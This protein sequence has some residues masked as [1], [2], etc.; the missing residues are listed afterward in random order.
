MAVVSARSDLRID[1]N[2][3]HLIFREWVATAAVQD[4]A[5]GG[6]VVVTI[7]MTTSATTPF[8]AD[9]LTLEIYVDAD[10][11]TQVHS[12]SLAPG[13][14]SQTV[15]LFM[16]SDTLTGSPTRCGTLRMRIHAV[17]TTG[18]P[19]GTYNV[20]TDLVN[21][22]PPSLASVATHDQGWIRST[23]TATV[24]TSNVSFGGAKPNPF[25]FPDPMFVRAVLGAI[26]Y[27]DP[28][29]RSVHLT[30]GTVFAAD[31]TS[32]TA[33][34]QNQ[35]NAVGNNFPASNSAQT[36]TVSVTQNAALATGATWTA[37]ANAT[38]AVNVDPRL[39][40]DNHLLVL[41]DNVVGTPPMSKNAARNRTNGDLGFIGES[42]V[43]ARAERQNGITIQDQM[44]D[45]GNL[46]PDVIASAVTAAQGGENGWRAGVGI[47]YTW[48]KTLPTGV[49][50]KTSTI[51]APGTI[52]GAGYLIGGTK[53]YTMDGSP[54]L[55][56]IIALIIALG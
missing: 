22:T 10:N 3:T 26:P 52:T 47:Y 46:N 7:V 16:T 38:D 20:D 1:D 41:N 42:I 40:I 53:A 48:S 14:A 11:A 29:A 12:Y 13:S 43:N 18:G 24:S 45:T 27:A 2:A 35:F 51:T 19:A 6:S 50:N 49:W 25:A 44:V 56:D 15:T 33:T 39:T 21:N 55:S 9:T 36:T 31:P 23:T 37:F 28:S 32:A 30:V 17:N 54:S 8:P 5:A 4:T 34:F